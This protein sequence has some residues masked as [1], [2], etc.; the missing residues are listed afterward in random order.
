MP[1]L[2]ALCWLIPLI[3]MS[4]P[5]I[6]IH[7]ILSGVCSNVAIL[8]GPSLITLPK[9]TQTFFHCCCSAPQSCPTLCVPWTA[10]CQASLSFTISLSLLK[11]TSTESVM[12]SNHLILCLLLLLLPSI[13]PSIRVFTKSPLFTSGGQ[14]IAVSTSVWIHYEERFSDG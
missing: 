10:T 9:I 8:E 12:P 4:F 1:L 7:K 6:F 11:L 2:P 3:G 14:S 5:Q 13:F